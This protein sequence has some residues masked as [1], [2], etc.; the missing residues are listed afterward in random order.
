[1]AILP[2]SR[3][4]VREREGVTAEWKRHSITRPAWDCCFWLQRY[5]K[6]F[7]IAFSHMSPSHPVLAVDFDFCEAPR[8]SPGWKQASWSSNF[9]EMWSFWLPK[10]RIGR[11]SPG[12]PGHS[13]LSTRCR[14]CLSAK[15]VVFSERRRGQAFAQMP[16][17]IATWDQ[18]FSLR[19]LLMSLRSQHREE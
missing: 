6:T 7:R 13:P 18:W 16:F 12:K 9:L 4:K 5:S 3:K 15:E 10:V 1:M 8:I 2:P 19:L 14:C 17:S 11:S